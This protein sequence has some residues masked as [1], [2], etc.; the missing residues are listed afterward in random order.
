MYLADSFS[1]R[2]FYLNEKAGK[3]KEATS[4][5]ELR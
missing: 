2:L 4:F 1:T 3:G 5:V